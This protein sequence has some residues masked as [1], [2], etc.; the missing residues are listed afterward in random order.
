MASYI[1]QLEC[2]ACSNSRTF[3]HHDEATQ[4]MIGQVEVSTLPRNAVVTCG[5]CGSTSLVR[6]WGDSVPFATTGYVGR[7]RRRRSQPATTEAGTSEST[8]TTAAL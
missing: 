6:C 4:R 7:R 1:R 5:R 8:N 2:L 3:V